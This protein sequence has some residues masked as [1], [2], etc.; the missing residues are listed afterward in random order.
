MFGGCEC[1]ATKLPQTSQP[2]AARKDD[3]ARFL[4]FAAANAARGAGLDQGKAL[5]IILPFSSEVCISESVDF[6][7]PFLFVAVSVRHMLC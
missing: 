5:H 6:E 3:A 1:G 7:L 2:A 4:G